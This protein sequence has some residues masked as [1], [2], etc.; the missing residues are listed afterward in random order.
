VRMPKGMF[1][2]GGSYYVR[3][4][5]GGREKWVSLGRDLGEATK[6]L[7]RLR[8][9]EQVTERITVAL[10]CERWLEGYVRTA[11]NG[12][13][14][15]LAAVRAS[16]YLL[17]F[18]GSRLLSK[19]GTEDL[20][21]YRVW[22]EGR[23]STP[24]TVA[25]VLS[26]AR[27]MFGWAEDCGLLAKSPVPRK[28]LPRIQ[29]RPPD[30]LTDEEAQA[31]VRIREPYGFVVRLG[32]GT[33]LRWGELTRVQ[34]TDVQNG[35]LVV[36]HTKTGRVRRV[37]LPPELR[38]ELR[39]RVGKL[40]P[41]SP[42]AQGSFARMVKRLSGVQGFHPH[43]LRH[44]FACKW[45]ERGGSLAALQAIL[46]HSTVVTTQRY[47]RLTDEAVRAEAERLAQA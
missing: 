32:L 31:V 42:R 44:T 8:A 34:S 47:A 1:K 38:A 40:V 15:K 20:R 24:Q 9:G 6:R 22:L 12:D 46:G 14:Q 5:A 7:H 29:E 37:P 23:V 33:G 16:K 21:A 35:V 39:N 28:L 4:Y 10:A 11:R 45:L 26:D 17:P 25:H 43:Q 19:I 2:R 36:H 3:L 18:L 41:F 27:C 30:R 13:G